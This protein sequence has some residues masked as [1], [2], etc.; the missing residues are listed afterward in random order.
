MQLTDETDSLIGLSFAFVGYGNQ[1][2]GSH[3]ATGNN[4]FR[5]VGSNVLDDYSGNIFSWDFDDGTDE[6]NVDDSHPSSVFPTFLE[7]NGAP[8]D[9]GGPVLVFLGG[10]Y[11]VAGVGSY[12]S[13]PIN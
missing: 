7:A 13:G 9:S 10:E 6:H 3:R 12:I 4:G 5:W 1:G 2:I 8:G 11:R